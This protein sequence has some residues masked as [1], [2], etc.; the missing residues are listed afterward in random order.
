[1]SVLGEQGR[2]FGLLIPAVHGTGEA[3][4]NFGQVSDE[5]GTLALPPHDVPPLLAIDDDVPVNRLDEIK[6]DLHEPVLGQLC[7][8]IL[9]LQ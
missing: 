6:N 8:R 9:N 3:P 5:L 2:R 4:L 7:T 1:M